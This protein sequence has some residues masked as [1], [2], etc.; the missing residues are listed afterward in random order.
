MKTM[1]SVVGILVASLS[2]IANSTAHAEN[3]NKPSESYQLEGFR[4][5]QPLTEVLSKPGCRIEQQFHP[6]SKDYDRYKGLGGKRDIFVREVHCD[7]QDEKSKDDNSTIIK[8]DYAQK[9]IAI[10]G[11]TLFKDVVDL[12]AIERKAIQQYGAVTKSTYAE[13]PLEKLGRG[14]TDKQGFFKFLCWGSCK[15]IT[16]TDGSYIIPGPDGRTTLVIVNNVMVSLFIPIEPPHTYA[17]MTMLSDND[18][19]AAYKNN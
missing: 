8:F 6:S 3:S 10:I 5:G 7:V 12:P 4:L 19:T 11:I 14:S 15:M 17:I 13:V 9:A 16:A 1:T 18:A 2:L